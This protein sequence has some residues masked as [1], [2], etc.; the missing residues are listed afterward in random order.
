MTK[1]QFIASVTAHYDELNALT[2][3]Q[4][5]P[6]RAMSRAKDVAPISKRGL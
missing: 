2:D 6:C 5:R 3:F 4:Q 1:E